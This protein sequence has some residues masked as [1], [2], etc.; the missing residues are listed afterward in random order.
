MWGGVILYTNSS[1]RKLL[2]TLTAFKDPKRFDPHAMLTFGFVYDAAKRSYAA[3]I[4][5]Y[6]SRPGKVKGS[7]LESFAEIQPQLHNSIRIGSPGSF[8]GEQLSPVVK[9]F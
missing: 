1:D 2:D 8:A 7:T 9:H 6:H 5:M 4:A 3:D